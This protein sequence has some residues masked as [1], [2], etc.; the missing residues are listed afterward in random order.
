MSG[1]PAYDGLGDCDKQC[2]HLAAHSDK[3]Q[4]DGGVLDHAPA[5][6]PGHAYG[7]YVLTLQVRSDKPAN[8]LQQFV[9]YFIFHGPSLEPIYILKT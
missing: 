7:P 9:G 6:H 1:S 4:H 5:A 2:P 8:F 3:E